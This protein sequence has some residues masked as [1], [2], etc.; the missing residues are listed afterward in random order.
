MIDNIIVHLMI[1]TSV[2]SSLVGDVVPQRWK[3]IG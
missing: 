3:L 2:S 1:N